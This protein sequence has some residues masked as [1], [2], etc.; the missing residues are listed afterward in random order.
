MRVLFVC[1]G[2]ICRSPTAEGVMRSLVEEAGLQGTI[3]IDSAGTGAWHVGSPPDQRAV[4]AARA[5]G[6][7][8]DGSARQ[9]TVDDVEDFDLVIA[10]DHDN[11]RELRRLAPG[12]Q[13]RSKIRLL[14]EFD[15][16]SA[17]TEEPEVPDPYYGAPGGF[18]EV[19]DLVDAAC[20]GLLAQIAGGEEG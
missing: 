1:L 15:P 2:N 4:A 16:A 14:R 20:N 7:T 18:D 3:E 13:E 19:L 5:R 8:L 17:G 9:V 10:M 6:I 11:L 12:E